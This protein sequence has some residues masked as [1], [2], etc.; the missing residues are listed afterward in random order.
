MVAVRQ[1]QGGA[2]E[3]ARAHPQC[4]DEQRVGVW[5]G[6]ATHAIKHQAH[7]WALQEGS[8]LG[9]IED[10]TR[11]TGVVEAAQVGCASGVSRELST[12]RS[13]AT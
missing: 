6:N 8:K 7:V 3:V 10:L 12:C 13:S 11:G 2:A 9:E 1:R 5:A 4:V